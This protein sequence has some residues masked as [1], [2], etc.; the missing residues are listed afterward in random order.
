MDL[1]T[2]VGWVLTL[3]LLFGAM[4]I[5]VGIGPY[6]DI[7]SIMIV[8]GGTIGVMMVGFKMETLKSV[9]KFYGIAVKPQQINLSETIKKLVD[10]STKARRDGILALETDVNNE[11]NLFMKKG[12]SMAVDGT[13]PDT[14][15]ALLEIDIDQSSSRHSA[16]IKIFDQVG[17][18]SGSMGMIG[19]LIGLVAMLLNMSDPSAIGPSMAVALLTTLYGAMIGNIIGA[20]V[21]NILSIRDADETLEKQMVL[22]GIMAIQSGDN[23]RT[24]EAKLLAF[25]PPKDRKSQF[26]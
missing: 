19:T 26:E 12:L 1:G 3:V 14:I 11:T 5:G 23:P 7:P 4:A 21:A 13:E 18:F 24:L 9:G 6:I 17:G 20:P 10:Y 2:V 15:R 22:E 16:N 8:F 25:L